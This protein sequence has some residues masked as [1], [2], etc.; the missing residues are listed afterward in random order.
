MIPCSSSCVWFIT[1]D[2]GLNI[3]KFHL[4]FSNHCILFP[5]WFGRTFYYRWY[6][7][8]HY[9]RHWTD[10]F[11]HLYY[12]CS[13]FLENY[14]AQCGFSPCYDYLLQ[15]FIFT[16]YPFNWES[17]S[18]FC[19]S[20][21]KSLWFFFHSCAFSSIFT[22]YCT[23]RISYHHLPYLCIPRCPLLWDNSQRVQNH[24]HLNPDIY[25]SLLIPA[26]LNL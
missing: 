21:Q 8:A 7:L 25:L 2:L 13:T 3:Y 6:H 12:L 18:E 23:S 11:V 19:S 16:L 5:S 20:M 15:F 26:F 4:P 22:F 10:T 17:D 1:Q 14:W 9:Y 24:S